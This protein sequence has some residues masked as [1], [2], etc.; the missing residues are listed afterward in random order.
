MGSL[1]PLAPLASPGWARLVPQGFQARLAHQGSRG[2]GGSQGYEGTRAS[3][4]PQGPLAYLGPQALL[5]LENQVLRGCQGPQDLGGSQGPRESLGLR[6]IE[7]SRAK[8]EWANQGFLEPQA[9]GVPPD[10]LVSLVQLAWANQVWM[11]FL[12]PLEIRVSL[13]L[14][15]CQDPGGNQELWAQKGPLGWMVWGYQGQQG[16]QGHRAHEG[17]KGSQAPGALLA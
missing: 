3:G 6:V 7:A 5:S 8:M 9:R 16:C 1:D 12:G 17:P 13:G 10:P 14:L 11:G 4:G 15:G 2:F